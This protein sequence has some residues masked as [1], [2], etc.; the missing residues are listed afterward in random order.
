METERKFGKIKKNMKI[1]LAHGIDKSKKI[2]LVTLK[3]LNLN[4]GILQKTVSFTRKRDLNINKNIN[5]NKLNKR[6]FISTMTTDQLI[7]LEMTTKKARLTLQFFA[8]I[9]FQAQNQ[10]L[11]KN[12]HQ[13][14]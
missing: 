4:G 6:K 9:Q 2:T 10:S 1:S 5:K 8:K 7:F 3:M 14:L 13:R 11:S 12:P